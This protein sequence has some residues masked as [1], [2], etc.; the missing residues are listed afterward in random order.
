MNAYQ[1]VFLFGFF[2][3]VAFTG[4]ILVMRDEGVFPFHKAE[5][6]ENKNVK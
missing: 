2:E 6:T 1:M 5:K 4:L 3:G